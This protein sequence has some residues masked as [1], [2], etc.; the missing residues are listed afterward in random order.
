MNK[1]KTILLIH[2]FLVYTPDIFAQTNKT[3]ETSKWQLRGEVAATYFGDEKF[4]G[5]AL[6]LSTI[7][8]ISDQWSCQLSAGLSEG[9]LYTLLPTA[10]MSHSI[11]NTEQ[12]AGQNIDLNLLTKLYATDKFELKVGIGGVYRRWAITTT[13]GLQ[14]SNVFNDD[15]IRLINSSVT[16]RKLNYIDAQLLADASYQITEKL[17]L[18]LNYTFQGNYISYGK[19]G[20]NVRL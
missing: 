5:N 9:S 17:G 19:I 12:H 6:F 18:S 4:W 11:V 14:V 1:V 2:L 15:D 10:S 16:I 7:Y 8:D 3:E 13:S 20:I